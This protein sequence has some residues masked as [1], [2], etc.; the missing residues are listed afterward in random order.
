MIEESSGDPKK[1]ME[2]IGFSTERYKIFSSKAEKIVETI[3]AQRE[4]AQPKDGERTE[5]SLR[6]RDLISIVEIERVLRKEELR[7]TKAYDTYLEKFR[8][9]DDEDLLIDDLPEAT[10][11]IERA[12]DKH[13]VVAQIFAFHASFVGF[14]MAVVYYLEN[15]EFLERIVTLAEINDQAEYLAMLAVEEVIKNH[16]SDLPPEDT[17]DAAYLIY[18]AMR[19][20]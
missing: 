16:V 15:E 10:P 1:F 3:L 8:D 13:A 12:S 4:E 18:G 6:L 14:V 19:L 11:L 9:S 2:A 17:R 20:G 5:H 7:Q